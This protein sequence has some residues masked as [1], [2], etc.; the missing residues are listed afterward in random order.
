MASRNRLSEV[1]PRPD[2]LLLGGKTFTLSPPNLNTLSNLEEHFDCPFTEVATHL[3]PTQKG[4]VAA[5][6]FTLT[7]MLQQSDPTVDEEWVGQQI[8]LENL[9][10]VTTKVMVAFAKGL[11]SVP[12]AMTRV[13]TGSRAE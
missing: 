10:P 7:A 9:E 8:S 5:L 4:F 3:D 1:N 12:E 13:G 2:Q 6:R 11:P